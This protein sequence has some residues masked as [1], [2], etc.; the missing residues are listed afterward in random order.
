MSG[1]SRCCPSRESRRSADSV[2]RNDFSLLQ[3]EPERA[4]HGA[5]I[6]FAAASQEQA[7][8]WWQQLTEADY[9]DDGTAGPETRLHPPTTTAL[10][11]ATPIAG[12]Q[13]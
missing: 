9:E 4:T 8:T 1:C 2:E 11:S 12:C 6:A 5:H 13:H 7:D 10:S 3:D